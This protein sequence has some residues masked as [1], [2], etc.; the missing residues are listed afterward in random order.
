MSMGN[1]NELLHHEKYRLLMCTLPQ[2]LLGIF[3]MF[4]IF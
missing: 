4:Q 3:F 2:I 1:I